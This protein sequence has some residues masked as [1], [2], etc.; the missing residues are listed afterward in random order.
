MKALFDTL[1]VWYA[2]CPYSA[3]IPIEALPF[4]GIMALPFISF[5]LFLLASAVSFFL[6]VIG[7]NH[8]AFYRYFPRIPWRSFYKIKMAYSRW[9]DVVFHTK[10]RSTG[11]F[12]PVLA[13]MCMLYRPN[14]IFLGRVWAWD[15]GLF[16]PVGTKVSRHIMV[17]AMTGAGKTTWLISMLALWRGS[18]WL[19][20]PKGQVTDA[21]QRC[22]SKRTW[23]VLRPYEMDNTDQWNPFDD[24]K[25]A[26]QRGGVT[27]LIK[28]CSHLSESLIV[29][30]Q[31]AKEVFWT[32]ASRQFLT[33][34][35][36]HVI[37]YHPEEDH[38][39]GYV[40]LLI[41]QAYRVEDED[42][43]V[44]TTNEEAHK[45]LHKIMD[46][47]KALGEMISN[48]ASAFTSSEGN[49]FKS[50]LSTLQEQTQWLDFPSVA[51]MLSSTT[52]PLS[53]AKTRSDVVFSLVL[54][55]LALRQKLKGLARLYTNFTAYTFEE[56][57]KKK[58]Q[59]L[60][61]IDEVQAQGYNET[62]DVALPVAR[63]Y[64]QTIVAISQDREG[65]QAIYNTSEAFIGNADLTYW[66]AT[67]HSSNLTKISELLGKTTLIETDDETGRKSYREVNV[68]DAEQ[69]GR[70]LEPDSG[71][72]IITR[73]GKRPIRIKQDP[74]YKALPVSRYDADPD[75]KE[76]LLKR[77]TRFL[78]NRK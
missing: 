8:P 71:N 13:V 61:I 19:I 51:F 74:Y 63:S 65:M 1:V 70:F 24:I 14:Q 46:E 21:L 50:L 53:D 9:V 49:T 18:A 58:G 39:L 23:V 6:R 32:N 10:S 72:A 35:V 67:S 11:G 55:V 73:A 28:W 3:F 76:P 22:D 68:M 31:G 37:T 54:P 52:R 59:C 62:L 26:L 64:G 47:N 36:A 60:T 75:H 38:T 33:A 43:T 78:I 4:I 25:A 7:C 45:L 69:V 56:I 27:G 15:V 5:G 12:A 40:R 2:R 66:M 42:G 20:D 41:C 30:P 29:T 16:Q 44:E 48:A 34:L 17:Y 77:I 57:K